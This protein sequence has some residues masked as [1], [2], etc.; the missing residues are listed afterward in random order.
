MPHSFNII[1]FGAV[2]LQTLSHE[3]D[4][5]PSLNGRD[6][7]DGL[8]GLSGAPG[9]TGLKGDP[10]YPGQTGVPGP[11]GSDGAPGKAGPLGP[12]G[13]QGE[14]GLPGQKGEMGL[15]GQKGDKCDADVTLVRKVSAI[16]NQMKDWEKKQS[17]LMK[18]LSFMSGVASAGGKIYITNGLQADYT[19]AQATCRDAGGTL[20]IPL[21]AQESNA[22]L[23]FAKAYNINTYLGINDIKDEGIYRDLTGR[24]VTYTPWESNE[25]NNDKN[26][27]CIEVLPSGGWNDGQ[28]PNTRLVVCQF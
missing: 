15:P 1:I 5:C 10:G 3:L 28:C 20:P 18:G 19:T 6:G 22:V 8:P 2:L 16:E 25:P 21:N 14:R 23:K 27:D 11:K 13:I 12:K 24:Q 26:E 17:Q 7:R 4:K 9:P